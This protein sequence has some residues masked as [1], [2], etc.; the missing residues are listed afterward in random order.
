[1]CIKLWRKKKKM[2]ENMNRDIVDVI[3]FMDDVKVEM[4]G[5]ASSGLLR[6]FIP[7]EKRRYTELF[8]EMS[9]RVSTMDPQDLPESHPPTVPV[10]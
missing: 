5:G 2:A 10:M 1:M 4:L 8:V 9:R 6:G 7:G 3:K